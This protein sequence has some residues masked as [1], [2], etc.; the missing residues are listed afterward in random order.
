MATTVIFAKATLMKDV[1]KQFLTSDNKNKLYISQK[2]INK[3][4]DS[5]L[6]IREQ[7][8]MKS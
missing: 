2:M 4:T 5:L 6:L 1:Y 3:R 7:R 8:Q